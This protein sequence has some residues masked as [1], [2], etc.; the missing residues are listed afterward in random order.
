VWIGEN[1]GGSQGV[2]EKVWGI[3]LGGLW[4]KAVQ[5]GEGGGIGE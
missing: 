5:E 1:E 3:V 2:E 4:G